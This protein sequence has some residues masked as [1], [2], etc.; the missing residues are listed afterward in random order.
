MI[1][2]Q[3]DGLAELNKVLS[4]LSA[5]VKPQLQKGLMKTGLQIQSGQF[6]IVSKKYFQYRW[7]LV[8][9]CLESVKAN[10]AREVV[11]SLSRIRW[12]SSG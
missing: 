8:K 12:N 9:C 1:D 2:V 10:F 3:I 6:R 4:S 5:Q 11:C 7:E